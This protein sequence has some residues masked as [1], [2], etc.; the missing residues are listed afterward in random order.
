MDINLNEIDRLYANKIG[1]TF[2][3]KHESLLSYYQEKINI[4]FKD[5][6]LL[7]NI[8]ELEVFLEDIETALLKPSSN[9]VSDYSNTVILDTPLSQLRFAMTKHN[10][11]QMQDLIRGTL[12]QIELSMMLN[13]ML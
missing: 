5:T 7:F 4:I 10:L 12:F 3:W 6:A 11:E 2:C 13:E 8:I 1:I 9:K